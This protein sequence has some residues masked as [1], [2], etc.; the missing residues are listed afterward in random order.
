[1]KEPAY[2]GDGIYAQ[3]DK[4]NNFILTTGSH[5]IKNAGATIYFGSLE[6]SA[7]LSYLGK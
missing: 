2:L 4:D 6:L 1:M 5:I 7:L 3:W